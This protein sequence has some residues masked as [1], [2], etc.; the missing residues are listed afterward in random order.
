MPRVSICVARPFTIAERIWTVAEPCYREIENATRDPELATF[1]EMNRAG[2]IMERAL[3]R[4]ATF[5]DTI[6]VCNLR[7]A[8]DD[9]N[10]GETLALPGVGLSRQPLGSWRKMHT[11]QNTSS[12]AA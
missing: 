5:A 12:V 2:I 10:A 4:K 7:L 1:A 11:P 3:N 9:Q 8:G 6:V